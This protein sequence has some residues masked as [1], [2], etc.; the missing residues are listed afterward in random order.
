MAIKLSHDHP[1]RVRYLVLVNS[2]GGSIWTSRGRSVRS[3]AE[4]PL[5]DWS[6]HFP[7]DLL[8]IGPFNRV[9]PML[10]EDALPNLLRNPLGLWKVAQMVRQVDLTAELEE[11]KRRR[12]PVVVLWGDHDQIIPRASF[13]ALCE[14]IGS[15]GKVVAGNH[16]W[17]LADP[18]TFGEVMTNAVAVARAARDRETAPPKAR[19]RRHPKQPSMVGAAAVK[20]HPLASP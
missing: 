14:A 18:D 13:E 3:M 8:G 1:R 2:V 7:A 12:L 4:R 15:Q 6:R 5:W 17:L 11:L 16:T 19:P 10:M 20:T 9:L